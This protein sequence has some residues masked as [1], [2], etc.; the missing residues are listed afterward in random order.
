MASFIDVDASLSD[1]DNAAPRFCAADGT[2]STEFVWLESVQLWLH[3]DSSLACK[4]REIGYCKKLLFIFDSSG[5]SG[6]DLGYNYATGLLG[7]DFDID[8]AMWVFDADKCDIDIQSLPESSSF[9]YLA[10][11]KKGIIHG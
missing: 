9:V 1:P 6:D 7:M 5:I 10:D 8:P 11:P 3:L 2:V 4:H